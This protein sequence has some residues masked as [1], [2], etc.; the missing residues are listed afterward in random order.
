[1]VSFSQMKTSQWQMAMETTDGMIL[2]DNTFLLRQSC[3][4]AVTD[5]S[6]ERHRYSGQLT[7]IQHIPKIFHADILKVLPDISQC[8][9]N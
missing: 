6:T 2:S 3:Q 7:A 4:K 9:F 1:M 8:T 5:S